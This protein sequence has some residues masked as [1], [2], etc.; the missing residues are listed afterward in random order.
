MAALLEA[1]CGL[2]VEFFGYIVFQGLFGLLGR[3]SG[4]RHKQVLDTA[5]TK[6]PHLIIELVQAKGISEVGHGGERYRYY[7]VHASNDNKNVSADGV[8]VRVTEIEK[9]SADGTVAAMSLAEPLPLRW[10]YQEDGIIPVM[11]G[12]PRSCLLGSIKP[13]GKF[14]LAVENAP[15]D[16]DVEVGADEEMIVGVQAVA[17]NAQSTPLRIKIA[18]DGEWSVHDEEMGRHLIVREVRDDDEANTTTPSANANV[19]DDEPLYA[20]RFD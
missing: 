14:L 9:R 12:H 7:H 10:R 17:N 8:S 6:D 3:K 19:N 4:H 11:I 15:P 2:V 18:W 1:L 5:S 16:V 20:R 13:G